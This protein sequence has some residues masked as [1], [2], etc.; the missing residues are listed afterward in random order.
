M[1][2]N[3]QYTRQIYAVLLILGNQEQAYL[4]NKCYKKFIFN[5]R[6]REKKRKSFS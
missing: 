3:K 6:Q 2:R 5:I 1:I 4:Q